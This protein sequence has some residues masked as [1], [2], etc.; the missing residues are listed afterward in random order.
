MKNLNLLNW[1]LLIIVIFIL[2]YILSPSVRQWIC[3]ISHKLKKKG[4]K[5]VNCETNVAGVITD[6]GECIPEAQVIYDTCIQL[7]SAMKDGD[8]CVGCGQNIGG[9]TSDAF[10]G[11]GV[12]VDGKCMALPDA[13]AGKICVPSSATV[14]PSALSYKRILVSG[15]DYKYYKNDGN[16]VT[17]GGSSFA[18]TE[19]SKADYV[20]AFVQT[21]KACPTGQIKV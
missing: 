10:S 5:C 1:L 3:G 16:T 18:D 20:A 7:N 2:T 9:K 12:I 11:N 4:S 17:Q 21:I 6:S 19:I 15:T 13:F 8:D 14:N